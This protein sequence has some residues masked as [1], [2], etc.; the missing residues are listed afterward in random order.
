M[1]KVTIIFVNG[2]MDYM[3][4]DTRDEAVDVIDAIMED[5]IVKYNGTYSQYN[6][7]NVAVIHLHE[8]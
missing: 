3:Y 8:C 1:Y 7:A 4:F 2:T 6:Y 5:D